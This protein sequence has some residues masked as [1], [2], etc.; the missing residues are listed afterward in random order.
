[1]NLLTNLINEHRAEVARRQAERETERKAE[2]ERR[3]RIKREAL[4]QI[5]MKGPLTGYEMAEM[6]D[7]S[8]VYASVSGYRHDVHVDCANGFV[9]TISYHHNPQ[10][11]GS[12][13]WGQ[14]RIGE[15]MA[16]GSSVATEW[17][18]NRETM[19]DYIGSRLEKWG[20][21]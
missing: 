12:G 6:L 21:A 16:D 8:E 4:H 19:R 18:T 17:F 2:D 5:A 11:P 14:P 3:E 7:G 20:G 15:R 10:H 9:L 1:M 13:E